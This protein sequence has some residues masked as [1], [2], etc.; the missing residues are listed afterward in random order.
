METQFIFAVV[1]KGVL[2][3]ILL[4]CSHGGHLTQML[5]LLEAFEGHKVVFVTYQS[6]RGDSLGQNHQVYLLQNIGRSPL[7]MLR[8][9]PLVIHIL[10]GEKPQLIISNGSEIAI[11]F[12]YLAKI[13]GIKTI[14]IESWSRITE[15][16]RTGKLVYPVADVFL[17]QWEQLLNAYGPKARFEGGIL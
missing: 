13:L 3:K 15:P 7:K 2:V 10:R 1:L 9:I 17:V 8:C 11:L 6:Q 14:F 5:R 12:F 4:V 16:S